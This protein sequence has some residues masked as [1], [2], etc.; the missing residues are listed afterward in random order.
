LVNIF[1]R[2]LIGV[3]EKWY[4]DLPRGMYETFN[5]MVLV[6][7]IHF[8]YSVHYDVVIEI[9]SAFHQEKSS[10]I[11]DHIQEWHRW[12][13]LIKAY[14]PQKFLLDWFLKSLQPYILKD[15]S[16]SKVTS[17]EEE[18]FKA[19]QIDIIYAQFRMLYNIL[20]DAPMSNYDPIKKLKPHADGIVGSTNV[21]SADLVTTHLKDLYLNQSIGGS[22]L[23]MSS[24]PTQL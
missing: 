19:Q 8:Q 22:S 16:T 13:R 5:H 3:V 11:S 6:F 4:I 20:P 24:T 7:L 14:I 15:V 23:S 18:I 1:Q 10:H 12:K 17:E 2:T 21:K 9:L